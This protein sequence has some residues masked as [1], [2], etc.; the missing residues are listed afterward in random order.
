MLFSTNIVTFWHHYGLASEVVALSLS[1]SFAFEPGFVD[2]ASLKNDLFLKVVAPRSWA[3][4]GALLGK[5][6]TWGRREWVRLA[7]WI[8]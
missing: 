3:R 5:V 4:D 1:G 6:I 2:V 8:C 7:T